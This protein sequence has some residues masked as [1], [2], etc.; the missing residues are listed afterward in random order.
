[1]YLPYKELRLIIE[2]CM[3]GNLSPEKRSE[4][5]ADKIWQAEAIAARIHGHD[6]PAEPANDGRRILAAALLASVRAQVSPEA[7]V[8][9]DKK[10]G[11]NSP[12]EPDTNPL[13]DPDSWIHDI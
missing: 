13:G 7:P 10:R 9:D 8:N 6:S 1:M 5:I 2:Q 12:V 11:H 4:L 3:P